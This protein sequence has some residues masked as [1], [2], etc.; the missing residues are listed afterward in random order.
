MSQNNVKS[1]FNN[2]YELS[3]LRNGDFKEI[4]FANTKGK[5][6]HK[7]LMKAAKYAAEYLNAEIKQFDAKYGVFSL[8]K[9]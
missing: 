3:T 4:I 5:T 2:D 9:Y 7:T 8:Y 6:H 1:I